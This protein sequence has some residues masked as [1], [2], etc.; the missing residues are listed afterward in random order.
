MI[1]RDDVKEYLDENLGELDL[2]IP[3][4]ISKTDLVETFCLYTEYDYSEWLKD[5]F[6]SFFNHGKPDWKWIRDRIEQYKL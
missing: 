2:L 6:N 5:N 4:N 1:D 3:E